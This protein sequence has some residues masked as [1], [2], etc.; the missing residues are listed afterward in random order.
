M[1]FAGHGID[2]LC[3]EPDARV[4]AVLARPVAGF[5]G[6]LGVGARFR[7]LAA[8]ILEPADRA[9]ALTAVTEVVNAAGCEIEFTVD[10]SPATAR[11]T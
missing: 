11:R 9:Q 6:R 5:P 2:L 10:T 1:A 8:G 3:L 7:D 4:A